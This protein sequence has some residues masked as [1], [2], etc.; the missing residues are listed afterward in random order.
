[1]LHS[2]DI[3]VGYL[4]F[5]RHEH[6]SIHKL[7]GQPEKENECRGNELDDE[8]V[9]FP[10]VVGEWKVEVGFAGEGGVI[11]SDGGRGHGGSML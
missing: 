6:G 4:L 10:F 7:I 1:M 5:G 8:G 9:S 11:M 3:S 2:I